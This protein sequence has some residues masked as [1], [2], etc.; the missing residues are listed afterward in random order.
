MAHLCSLPLMAV[1]M[2][3]L[4]SA[5]FS[6]LEI[7]DPYVFDQR[8]FVTTVQCKAGQIRALPNFSAGGRC[9]LPRGLG[10]YSVAQISL[11][12]RSVLLP[13]YIEAD[14]ALY[15]TGGRGRVAFVHEERLVER[16]L[17]DGDV[18]AIA[19]GIP[20]Y[21]LNTDDSRRLFIHCLLRTQ[22]ST[23]GLYE[24]FYV[25]GGRNPQNVLS[26]F[27]EDVLQAAFNSSKAVL[28]PMLVSGFN[29]GA[30]IR[31][32]REQMERLS[33]GRIKGFGGSEEPQPFNLLYRNPDFSNNNGEIFTADA[34]DHRVLRRLNVGVQLLNLK[35]RSMTAPH[36]DTRSTRIGIVRN[37]RGILELVRPQEQEQQ[38]QQQQGPTYQKLRANLNP[39]TV[40][41]TRPGYPSTVIASGNEALQILY[42]DNYSQ[43]S[44]RQFLAGRSNVLRYLPREIKRLVFPSSAE[45]IEATLEAQEDEVLLNAQ[46]GRADQ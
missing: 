2:L 35:P 34:A 32:S 44:R 26:Q 36:Y 30:I 41:L 28:D 19:A 25:V 33:R 27:S 21:I 3:L 12:P 45:E 29:R 20:F 11:E 10:D 17:R 15:V 46:Q 6:E 13:H 18:Y 7:E 23:T 40:F 8:S 24:S 43:G 9:E 42:L 5:C 4:A 31:V 16:Q 39:G 37:G 14:L 22:C 38:Q 1:L